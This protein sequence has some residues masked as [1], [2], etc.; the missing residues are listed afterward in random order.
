MKDYKISIALIIPLIVS[1]AINVILLLKNDSRGVSPRMI[2]AAID[3]Y[4]RTLNDHALTIL[5][6]EVGGDSILPAAVVVELARNESGGYSSPVCKSCRN[7]FGIKYIGATSKR[8]AYRATTA[9]RGLHG[10]QYYDS[11]LESVIDLKLYLQYHGAHLQG[12][13]ATPGY[14]QRLQARAAIRKQFKN[15]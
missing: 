9:T 6:G 7:L 15:Q 5:W 2:P 3:N 10:Y 12:Y 13:S 4:Q 11:W 1:V 14:L 8:P